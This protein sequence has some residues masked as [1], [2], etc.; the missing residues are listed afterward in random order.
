MKDIKGYSTVSVTSKDIRVS[1]LSYKQAMMPMWFM[2]FR[3]KDRPYYFAMN[4]QT[5]K[6]G[7]E[8]PVNKVR[9][10]LVSFGIPLII[11]VILS[12]ILA[13]LGAGA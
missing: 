6:F 5:G 8:I 11:A 12:F 7:G 3:Y 4:G 1:A 10:A 9:V 2:T 13:F